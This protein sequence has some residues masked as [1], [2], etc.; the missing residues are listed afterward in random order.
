MKPPA[1]VSAAL[2]GAVA[3]GVERAVRSPQARLARLS[4]SSIATAS[5]AG[6]ITDFLN[7]AYYA[8]D[9]HERELSNLRLA[10]AVLTTDWYRRGG[11]RLGA[12][13]VVRYH[14]SFGRLRLST[15]RSPRGRLSREEL[16][17]GAVGLLGP[18]FSDAATNPD[19][20]GWGV[21]FPT[22]SE[23]EGYDHGRRMANVRLGPPTPPSTAAGDQVWHTYPPVEVPSAQAAVDVILAV[24]RWP[25][26]A[27]SLGRFTPLRPGGLADQTFEIEVV[28]FPTSRTPVW[29]RAY[30]TITEL[31]TG[32]DPER[33]DAWRREVVDG[34]RSHSPDEPSPIPDG[35]EL[36]AGFDL[37]C[38]EGHFMGDA[39]NRLVCYTH[40]GRAYLRAAGTWDP[41]SWHLATMYD[42]VGRDAQHAFWG[43]GTPEESMLHQVGIAAAAAGAAA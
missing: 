18:W 4:G 11:D 31:V 6:W 1:I 35:A 21:V 13:D 9:R 40:D 37:T 16:L 25:D 20:T 23:R 10:F 2:G 32:A 24:E 3:L 34:F 26:C 5:A 29:L 41:M 22:R 42:R 17:E 33:R 8:H 36:V 7:A 43:M 15:N 14:R 39:K 38:H 28:G 12:T 19:R 30:V 27:S